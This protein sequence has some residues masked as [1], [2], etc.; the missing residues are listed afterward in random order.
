MALSVLDGVDIE[1]FSHTPALRLHGIEG[2]GTSIV[3]YTTDIP[4][5]TN[6]GSPLLIG[7]GS[8]HH[9]HT[10]EERIPKAQIR[11]AIGLYQRLARALK[12]SAREN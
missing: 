11:E 8:I 7:P 12:D 6:W 4:K 2:F 1:F 3:K 5:L 10:V 9:A